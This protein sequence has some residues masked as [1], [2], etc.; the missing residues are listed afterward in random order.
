ME[1]LRADRNEMNR[2]WKQF[3]EEWKTGGH[4]AFIRDLN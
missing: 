2:I 3:Q 1:D 4:F